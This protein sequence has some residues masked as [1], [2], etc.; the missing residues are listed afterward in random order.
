MPIRKGRD[1]G[2]GGVGS[3]GGSGREGCFGGGNGGLEGKIGN[4][5]CSLDF[6]SYFCTTK[7]EDSPILDRRSRSSAGRAQHF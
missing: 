4:K 2:C 5:F 3:S 7:I 6:F 1:A